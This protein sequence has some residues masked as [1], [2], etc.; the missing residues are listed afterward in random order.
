MQEKEEKYTAL[1]KTQDKILDIVAK[2]QLGLYLTGGIL[3]YKRF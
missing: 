3:I 2:E 1:Y